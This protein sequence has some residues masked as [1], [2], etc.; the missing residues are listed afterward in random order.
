MHGLIRPLVVIGGFT[1]FSSCDWFNE[2]A[3]YKVWKIDCYR[4]QAV[5]WA[6]SLQTVIMFTGMLVL[7][8]KG[9]SDAG[10]WARVWGVASESGRLS[11]AINIDPNPF[12]YMSIWIAI[13]C[14]IPFWLAQYGL[15]QM[16]VQRYC[17]LP[18]LKEAREVSLALLVL[19]SEY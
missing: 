2:K 19:S 9:T 5:V 12:Q 8:V 10:G 4:F 13:I 17:S 14:A 16:A 6:D 1:V 11:P 18:T 15:S 7:V 3:A